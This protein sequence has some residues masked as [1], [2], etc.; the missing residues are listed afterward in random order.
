MSTVLS[1]VAMETGNWSVTSF[2]NNLDQSLRAWGNLLVA[3]IG[4]VMVI[5]A[6]VK[7]AQGLISHG[8]T[9]VNWVVNLLMFFLGGALAFGGGWG[10]VQNIS[11]GGQS[12]LETLGTSTVIVSELSVENTVDIALPIDILP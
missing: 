9:Q 4:I 1:N 5:V 2:L 7:I 12:T 10:L 6:V 8:K 11:K 3:I